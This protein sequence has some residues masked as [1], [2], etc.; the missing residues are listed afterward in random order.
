MG[1][2]QIS[3]AIYQKEAKS[4]LGLTKIRNF[5]SGKEKSAKEGLRSS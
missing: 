3:T 2:F 5:I 1:D 4:M